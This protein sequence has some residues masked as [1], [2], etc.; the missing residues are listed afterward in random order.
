MADLVGQR[1]R[2]VSVE[3]TPRLAELL[4]ETL[5]VNGSLV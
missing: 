1:G 4:A 5:D 3:P 2:V